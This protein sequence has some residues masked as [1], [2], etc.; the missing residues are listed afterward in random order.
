MSETEQPSVLQTHEQ[1]IN[2][3]RDQEDLA[4]ERKSTSSGPPDGGFQAWLQVAGAFCLYFNS[5]L[6]VKAEMSKEH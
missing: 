4:P 5:W 1:T 3:A 2:L 6:V